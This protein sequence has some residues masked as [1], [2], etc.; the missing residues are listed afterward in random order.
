MSAVDF[1]GLFSFI[2][3]LPFS[4]QINQVIPTVSLHLAIIWCFLRLSLQGKQTFESFCK[5]RLILSVPLNYFHLLNLDY[6]MFCD[7][8]SLRK[9]VKKHLK[10]KHSTNTALQSLLHSHSP[11]LRQNNIWLSFLA[12]IIH[13]SRAHDN[14]NFLKGGHL[15]FNVFT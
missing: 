14:N 11:C 5:K 6:F 12:A 7:R 4:P 9:R 3:L 8:F 13:W 15:R 10:W 1:L 2:K